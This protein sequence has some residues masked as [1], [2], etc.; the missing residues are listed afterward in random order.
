MQIWRLGEVTSLVQEVAGTGFESRL[1]GTSVC[2]VN[3]S[4]EW[5]IQGTNQTLGWGRP[6]TQGRGVQGNMKNPDRTSA[7]NSLC[8]STLVP[9]KGTW[10]SCAPATG[11]LPVCVSELTARSRLRP[12]GTICIQDRVQMWTEKVDWQPGG[13]E[14]E[15]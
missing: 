10:D 7:S 5:Q 6:I 12:T 8:L 1:S 13:S 3:C 11:N 14:G 2:T 4:T 9:A 15:G